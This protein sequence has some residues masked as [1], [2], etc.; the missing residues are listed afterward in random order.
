M[1]LIPLAV[2]VLAAI[3]PGEVRGEIQHRLLK[4]VEVGKE[5]HGERPN[6]A[7]LWVPVPERTMLVH[8]ACLVMLCVVSQ[9][10]QHLRSSH[11]LGKGGC[12]GAGVLTGTRLPGAISSTGIVIWNRS[13]Q[14]RIWALSP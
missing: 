12:E 11:Q 8:S 5:E 13:D 2:P 10:R 6:T 7:E 1:V 14:C 3:Q 9:G 4:D